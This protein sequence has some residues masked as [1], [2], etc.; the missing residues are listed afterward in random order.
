MREI[1]REPKRSNEPRPTN[2]RA[3]LL[4]LVVVVIAMATLAM[5]NF[6]QSMLISHESS[7]ISNGQ[8]QARMCAESGAQS[9]RLLLAYPAAQRLEMGGTW[10]N[11]QLFQAV[12]VIP[13]VDPNR[14]A[15]FTVISPSLDEF[16]N[17]TGLRYGLQNESAKLN[18]LTLA[19]LDGLAAS[20]D[21]ASAA[22]GGGAAAGGDPADP[23]SALTSALASDMTSSATENLAAD[24]LMALPGMTEEIADAI[25]DFLD[26]DDI[27]RPYGAEFEDYYSQ[28][29]PPYKPAD[30]PINSIEQLLLVR[31]VTPALLFGYDENRNGFLD[32]AE[33]TKMN[34]GVQPGMAPGAAAVATDPSI[35]PPPP[36]G[37]APFLTIHSAEKNLAR[38]GMERVNI[39]SDD[40]QLLYDDLVAVL[41]NETWASFIVAYRLAG[42]PGGN[43]TSPL[44]ALAGMAAAESDQSDS[45]M[46]T[47]LLSMAQPAG[48]N[49]QQSPPQPWSSD[50][51]SSFDLS[52]SGSVKFNQVLDLFDATVAVQGGQNGQE[53]TFASPFTSLDLALVSPTIMDYLTTVD[54]PAVPG[55]INIMECPQEILYGIPGLRDEVIEQILEARVDGSDSETRFFETWLAA[56]GI[57]TIDEMR[58]ILPLVTCGGDVFKAQIIGYLEGNAAFSRVEAIVS[59]A[60]E[61]PQ[62]LFFRKMDHLGRGFDI[63]TLG[64]RFDAG[65]QG[66]GMIQ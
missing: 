26:E 60:G 33:Q 41:G 31:G 56:E 3:F 45:V 16:G 59:G 38:D 5:L 2:R 47:E 4:V 65:M 36:L 39:N 29:Q 1:K 64:Q 43:G 52:Q 14:R 50:A 12:N 63:P 23:T 15:N 13:D 10:E 18:L 48:N 30:G 40:L 49:Q 11:P 27:T 57:L 22:T 51:L 37:W 44:V 28:L 32:Q 8:L 19:Q 24:I 55:R 35:G 61:L 17:Y 62:I 21:M 58:A 25:L 9:I 53:T 20:G 66:G 46:A 7:R 42:T 6:S 54:A 34:S